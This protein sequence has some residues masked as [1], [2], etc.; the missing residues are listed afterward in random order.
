MSSVTWLRSVI[1]RLGKLC[2]GNRHLIDGRMQSDWL[3]LAERLAA[4]S[5]CAPI[6]PGSS[7]SLRHQGARGRLTGESRKIDLLDMWAWVGHEIG[8]DTAII[9]EKDAEAR[10]SKPGGQVGCYWVRCPL[11]G[12]DLAECDGEVLQCTGCRT[13]SVPSIYHGPGDEVHSRSCRSFTVALA[14]KKRK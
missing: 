2:K 12:E 1:Q 7:I 8:L 3:Y 6:T 11:Y 5:R 4:I 13:V 9:L 14:V 10:R